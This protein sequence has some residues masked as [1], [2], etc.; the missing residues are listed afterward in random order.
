MF[1]TAL[2]VPFTCMRMC[3][4]RIFIGETWQ[5]GSLNDAESASCIDTLAK[6]SMKW[7]EFCMK[8][9]QTN[10][11]V[12]T[13]KANQRRTPVWIARKRLTSATRMAFACVDYPVVPY[14]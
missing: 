14:D 8:A 6:I 13:L 11:Y 7:T 1:P 12:L 9:L 4:F 5:R 10:P 3:A 2:S